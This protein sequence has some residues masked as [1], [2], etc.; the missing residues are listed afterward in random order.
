MNI[1][2]EQFKNNKMLKYK[3]VKFV[4]VDDWDNLV[5]ETY[6]KPYNFQQQ[7]GCKDRQVVDITVPTFDIDYGT[8]DTND[9]EKQG[10]SFKA[11]LERD[12]E[13][14]IPNEEYIWQRKSFWEWD[15]YPHINMLIND[16]H[17]KGLLE[18]G[19]YKIN[20]DW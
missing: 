16:L 20:I 9:G 2:E 17:S 8:E 1:V 6:R 12:P 10:V 19:N 7:D 13:E 14:P 5:Q 15:F 4:D 18:A 11:W 3:L